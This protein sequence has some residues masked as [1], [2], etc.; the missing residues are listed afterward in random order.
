MLTSRP[1]AESQRLT[2][3]M[4]ART[5]QPDKAAAIHPAIRNKFV[6]SDAQFIAAADWDA[7][8]KLD[9]PPHSNPMV[10][11][12]VAIDA[13]TKRDST[14]IV[15]VAGEKDNVVLRYH[16]IFQPTTNK[17]I[18][19][20]EVEQCLIDLKK[21]YPNAVLV[22]DQYQLASVVQRLS[23]LGWRCEEFIQSPQNLS[24]C[25]Q[26]LYDLTKYQ[27]LILYPDSKMRDAALRA[28]ITENTTGM[29]LAKQQSDDIITALAMAAYRCTQRHSQSVD[30]SWKYRAFDPNFR[31]ED[32]PPLPE[33]EHGPPGAG[34][35]WWRGRPQVQ[36]SSA[37]E[38][39]RNYYLALETAFRWGPRR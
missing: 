34:G 37:N 30:L 14:A 26:C 4:A 17:P 29:R 7:C 39:L 28:V 31:D 10:P 33:P 21:K 25:T 5:A 6:S 2:R 24:A 27:R 13:S 3:S 18:D 15:A 23:K 38:R 35:D 20:E 32:L 1:V 8:V 11:I 12:I 19:F 36:T 16:K 9:K 22:Y